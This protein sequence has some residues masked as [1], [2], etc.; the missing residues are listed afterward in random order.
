[1]NYCERLIN[2]L[3]DVYND[4]SVELAEELSSYREQLETVVESKYNGDFQ[5]FVDNNLQNSDYYYLID[6][7][8]NLYYSDDVLGL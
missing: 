5:E 2:E 4:Y 3:V 1:M 6:F 8:N 7:V